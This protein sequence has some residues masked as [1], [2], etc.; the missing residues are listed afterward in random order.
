MEKD[1]YNKFA[2]LSTDELIKLADSYGIDIPQDLERIFII[3]E[4]IEY[5]N[6]EQLK[7][8]EQEPK[9]DININPS[10]SET[11]ALPKQ[12]NISYIDVII[13]DPLWIYAFWEVKEQDK[14]IHEKADGFKGYCL[15]V[16]PLNEDN[17]AS[18]TKDDSFT[19]PIDANEDARYIGFAGF[20]DF[21]DFADHSSLTSNRYLIKLAAIRGEAE[22]QIAISQPFCL[23][24]LIKN[25][26]IQKMKEDS[27]YR[28]SGIADL[29]IIINI[30]RQFGDKEQ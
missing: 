12:Y 10:Y 2:S 20:A 21:A 19:I 3:E 16:I 4:L 22:I 29:P 14:E 13:R 6:S 30:E 8:G 7:T 24:R 27:L 11:A 28:L 17:T 23:P 18:Q 25:E 9:E 26:D 1:S 15:R 5:F